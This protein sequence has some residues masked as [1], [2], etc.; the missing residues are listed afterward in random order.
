MTSW[1]RWTTCG[2]L[3]GLTFA[4][5]LPTGHAA[6]PATPSPMREYRTDSSQ[7][8]EV[9]GVGEW[10][11][12]HDQAVLPE[13][14]FEYP[15]NWLL[16]ADTRHK[17]LYQQ[18]MALGP[19]HP[20]SRYRANLVVRRMPTAAQGGSYKDL[21]ALVAAR[22][23]QWAAYPNFQLASEREETAA[24]VSGLRIDYLYTA[25]LPAQSVQAV[26]TTIQ[27]STVSLALGGALY[28]ISY[29]ADARDYATYEPVFRH[30]LERLQRIQTP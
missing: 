9:S 22:R 2:A 1:V 14:T 12:Y 17:E 6:S 23:K 15:K 19:A 7:A 24:G 25:P 30:A 18:V 20:N 5:H 13:L 11:A 26:P 10:T 27:T 16:G 3:V 29:S 8:P 21:Q 4:G 28:E